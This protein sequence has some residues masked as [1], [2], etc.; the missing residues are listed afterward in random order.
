[1][2]LQTLLPAW[3][4]ALPAAG[5]HWHCELLVSVRAPAALLLER[6]GPASC[7]AGRWCAC[8]SLQGQGQAAVCEMQASPA[9]RHMCHQWTHSMCKILCCYILGWPGQL[10]PPLHCAVLHVPLTQQA[11]RLTIYMLMVLVLAVCCG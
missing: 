3:R 8:A 2:L 9:L 7:C 6:P 10:H 1:V 5:L 4:Q 11:G